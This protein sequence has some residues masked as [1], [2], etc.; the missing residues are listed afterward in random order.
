MKKDVQRFC[1]QCI[2]CRKVK[3]IVQPHKLYTPLPVPIEPWV[4]ISMDFF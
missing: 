1:E 3:S 4:D 2:A